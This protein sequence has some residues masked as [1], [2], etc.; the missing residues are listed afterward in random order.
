MFFV[1]KVV[2]YVRAY[3][4]Y[5][6][7]AEASTNKMITHLPRYWSR[8]QERHH[9]TP[10]YTEAKRRWMIYLIITKI[11]YIYNTVDQAEVCA[12][13]NIGK[14]WPVVEQSLYSAVL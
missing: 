4:Y 12:D 5:E 3:K 11:F 9:A 14:I 7:N 2:Y 8:Y 1:G 6:L 13:I 10:M